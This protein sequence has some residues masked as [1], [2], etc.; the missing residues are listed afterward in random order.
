MGRKTIEQIKTSEAEASFESDRTLIE[1]AMRFEQ[2]SFDQL[3]SILK[4]LACVGVF[5]CTQRRNAVV[6]L[7]GGSAFPSLAYDLVQVLFHIANRG[8]GDQVSLYI[9]RVS[10]VLLFGITFIVPLVVIRGLP[11]LA[12]HGSHAHCD[13]LLRWSIWY[14]A[15]LLMVAFYSCRGRCS[16]YEWNVER[17]LWFCWSCLAS[18]HLVLTIVLFSVATLPFAVIDAGSLMCTMFYIMLGALYQSLRELHFFKGFRRWVEHGL[19]S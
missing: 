18:L 19:F 15:N 7:L 10:M 11:R 5:A 2:T 12:R 1:G 8:M 3:D 4:E 16:R 6:A 9:M 14:P 17:K 13:R